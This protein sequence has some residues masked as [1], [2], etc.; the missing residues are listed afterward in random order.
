MARKRSS[1][2]PAGSKFVQVTTWVIAILVILS[3]VLAVL[4]LSQ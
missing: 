3:M 1:T 4:P 2:G